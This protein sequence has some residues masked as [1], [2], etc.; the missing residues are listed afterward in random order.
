MEL[1]GINSRAA[2]DDSRATGEAGLQSEPTYRSADTPRG[3]VLTSFT[4][5]TVGAVVCP[6]KVQQIT[7]LYLYE[8]Y[9]VFRSQSVDVRNAF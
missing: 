6:K 3:Y 7:M 5:V 2:S 4:E 8:S 1:C 9:L